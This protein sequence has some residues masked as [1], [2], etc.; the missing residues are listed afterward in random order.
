M[1]KIHICI[2][3]HKTVHTD[4][5]KYCSVFLNSIPWLTYCNSLSTKPSHYS[6]SGFAWHCLPLS[7][8]L[9]LQKFSN[10]EHNIKHQSGGIPMV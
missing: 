9:M 10:I 4:D 8:H 6:K 5:F 2:K 7:S 3:L 1:G